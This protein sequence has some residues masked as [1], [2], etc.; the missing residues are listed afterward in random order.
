M[1]KNRYSLKLS[2]NEVH[3]LSLSI[4]QAF[5]KQGTSKDLSIWLALTVL[6]K[7]LNRTAITFYTPG[8]ILFSLNQSEALAFHLLYMKGHIPSNFITEQVNTPIHK[9]I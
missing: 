8:Q 4:Q 9:S 7:V 3:V 1:L 2:S 5:E 6:Q